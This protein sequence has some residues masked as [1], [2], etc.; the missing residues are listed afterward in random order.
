MLVG[1]VLMG[2]TLLVAYLPAR[3]ALGIGPLAAL[4]YD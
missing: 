4:R 2:A 3:R 1:G